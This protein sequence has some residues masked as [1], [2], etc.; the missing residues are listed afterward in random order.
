V[1]PHQARGTTLRFWESDFV[2]FSRV[3]GRP[4]GPT[5]PSSTP[6][7]LTNRIPVGLAAVR[8]G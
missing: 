7:A 4:G 6:K 8:V 5:E 3:P 1:L 2:T